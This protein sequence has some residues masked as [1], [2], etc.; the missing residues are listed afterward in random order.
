MKKDVTSIARFDLS[1]SYPDLAHTM[2]CLRNSA[3][4][5]TENHY[6]LGD[7]IICNRKFVSSR[8]KWLSDISRNLRRENSEHLHCILAVRIFGLL[9][10]YEKIPWM[11]ISQGTLEEWK[12]K[13][14][15]FF[16]AE[17]VAKKKNHSTATTW[18][19]DAC[20]SSLSNI[21]TNW[22]RFV[23]MISKIYSRK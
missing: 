4:G 19:S 18:T 16:V 3:N 2:R 14:L 1:S 21:S 8:K 9:R 15:T 22:K 13:L 7:G 6:Q 5:S 17:N 20:T 10:T 12:V 23:W 11:P